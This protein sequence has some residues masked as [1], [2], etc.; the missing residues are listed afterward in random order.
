MRSFEKGDY[1]ER[2]HI[3]RL[4]YLLGKARYLQG[5]HVKAIECFKQAMKH[6]PN[7]WV[8]IIVF[9]CSNFIFL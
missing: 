3:F 6:E 5:E 2:I 4:L 1:K 7:N 8:L 9:S